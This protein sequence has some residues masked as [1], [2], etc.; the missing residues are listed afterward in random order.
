MTWAVNFTDRP[1]PEALEVLDSFTVNTLPHGIHAY[2]TEAVK[3]LQAAYGPNVPITISASGH[4]FTG[5]RGNYDLSNASITVKR[6]VE[7]VPATPEPE[8]A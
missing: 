2:L 7:V 5:E 4:L 1:A 8:P 3:A 6:G